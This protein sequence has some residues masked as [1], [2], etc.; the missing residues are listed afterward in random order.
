M[1][2]GSL[3]ND[4]GDPKDDVMCKD[5]YVIYRAGGPYGKKN[6]ARGL[7]YGPRPSASGRTQDLGFFP[8][9]TDLAR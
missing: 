1:G 4:D 7:E 2:T 6:C 5:I 8:I 9:R 3:S